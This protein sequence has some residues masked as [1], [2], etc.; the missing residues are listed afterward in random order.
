MST[1]LLSRQFLQE[2]ED[3]VFDMLVDFEDQMV[4]ALVDNKGLSYGDME[5]DP[6][7]RM[8]KFL[9]D[10]M[11]GVNAAMERVDEG[12]ARRR[13]SQFTRDAERQGMV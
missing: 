3:L 5:L 4:K 7:E 6:Q 1:V 9:D 11:G 2:V 8:L 13:R 10:E 12:E